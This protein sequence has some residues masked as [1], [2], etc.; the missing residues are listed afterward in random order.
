MFVYKILTPF[1]S[2]QILLK[3]LFQMNQGLEECI[4]KMMPRNVLPECMYVRHVP[5]ACGDQEWAS[6]PLKLE[7]QMVLGAT[8]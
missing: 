8:M 6:E 4:M 5:G 7:L 1:W 3:I 2:L